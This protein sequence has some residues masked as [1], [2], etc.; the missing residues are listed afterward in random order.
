MSIIRFI[1]G[2]QLSLALFLL[3]V[4]SLVSISEQAVGSDKTAYLS[5]REGALLETS[6][7]FH[8]DSARSITC[9][10]CSSGE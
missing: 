10:G 5:S 8:S 3:P 1:V 6:S 4:F 9:E 2:L 7:S